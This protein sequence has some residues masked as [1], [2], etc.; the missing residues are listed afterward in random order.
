MDPVF[1]Y[2]EHPQ[3]LSDYE[4]RAVILENLPRWKA[5]CDD[6]AADTVILQQHAFGSSSAE[7]FL[8]SVAIKY[9]G[10]VKKHVTVVP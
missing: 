10:L 1:Y 7:L 9:A 3:F 6:V 8:M 5:A 4:V 2:V